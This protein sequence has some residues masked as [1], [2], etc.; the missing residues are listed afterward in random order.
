MLGDSYFK[1]QVPCFLESEESAPLTQA[2]GGREFLALREMALFLL[3]VRGHL[4]GL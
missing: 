1:S 3:S 4:L 2:G